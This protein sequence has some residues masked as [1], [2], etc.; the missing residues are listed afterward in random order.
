[1][2]T[3]S[4]TVPA[5][6]CSHCTHTIEMEISELEGVLSVQADEAS[7]KVVVNFAAPAGEEQIKTLLAEIGY[8][9]QGLISL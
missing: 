6:H 9:V 1:M 3:V 8:P 5:I 4:Y 2:T 7:K